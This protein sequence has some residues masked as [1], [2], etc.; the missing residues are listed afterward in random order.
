[1]E[2]RIISIANRKVGKDQPCFIIGEAGVNH[3]G[4]LETALQL[5][6]VAV[7][8]GCDAVKFQTF[9]SEKVISPSAPKAAYQLETTGDAETQLEM[10]RKLELPFEAFR[11]LN[12]YCFD[13]G[14]L[15]LSTPF[16]DES[17]AFLVELP[18]HALK[19]P[20]GE[21]TNLPFVE[22]LARKGLPLIVS[23]GMATIDEVAAA[24]DAVRTAGNP[25]F[26][27]LHCV[28]S[29]PA[30]PSSMNLRAMRT[31]EDTFGV[32]AGLSDHTVGTEISLAAVALGACV[33]EKHFTLSHN[34]LGPDHRASLEP[35]ELVSLVKGV[36]NI[37]AALG[38]GF[39]RPVP[40]ELNTAAV[41][42][43]SLF[44]ARFIPGG[45]ALT[46]DMIDILR[47]GIGLPPAMRSQVLG[48]RARHDIEAGTLLSLDML[49]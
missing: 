18:V 27:L 2:T 1:M 21:L 35:H 41:A 44:A 12:R 14:I 17:A 38:D 30:A 9:K 16:D 3:N 36:R 29:Y 4:C 13:K 43:R 37:E 39:K 47:P 40:E 31:L 11:D 15:F 5:I 10:V 7:E 24:L 26:V 22:N 45:A 32:S 6:D 42:R 25:P 8:A 20:S 19:I 34:L 46:L 49:A 28:S 33:V 48:R 23:T